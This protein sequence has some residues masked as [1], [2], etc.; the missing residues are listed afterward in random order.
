MN[1]KY[2]VEHVK[3]NIAFLTFTNLFY[4]I[5]IMACQKLPDTF[6]TASRV[7]ICCYFCFPFSSLKKSIVDTQHG[8]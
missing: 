6:W 1:I 8:V 7:I 4:G 3:V 5:V 2:P